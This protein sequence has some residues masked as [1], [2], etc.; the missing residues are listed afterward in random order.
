MDLER[1]N[2]SPVPSHGDRPAGRGAGVADAT[3]QEP[4]SPGPED[5]GGQSDRGDGACTGSEETGPLFQEPQSSGLGKGGTFSACQGAQPS[6]S[7]SVF[8]FSFFFFF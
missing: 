1:K 5:W 8:L 4:L 3:G 6:F 2:H 7:S